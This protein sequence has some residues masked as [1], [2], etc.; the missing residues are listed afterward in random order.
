MCLNIEI[1]YMAMRSDV[2]AIQ[3]LYY[4]TRETPCH[5]KYQKFKAGKNV[6]CHTGFCNGGFLIKSYQWKIRIF[7][8]CIYVVYIVVVVV[9]EIQP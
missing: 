4:S 6:K 2:L 1:K 3:Y 8:I 5:E 7:A 9:S